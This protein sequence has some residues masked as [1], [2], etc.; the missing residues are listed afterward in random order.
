MERFELERGRDRD[1]ATLGAGLAAL[2]RH[3]ADLHGWH[4]DNTIG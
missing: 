4:R 2:H 1:A 3:T